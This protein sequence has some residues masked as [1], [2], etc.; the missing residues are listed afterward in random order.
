MSREKNM[1]QEKELLQARKNHKL[2]K[3]IIIVNNNQKK[4]NDQSILDQVKQSSIPKNICAIDCYLDYINNKQD[5]N[6]ITQKV[7]INT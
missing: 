1:M 4:N 2:N 3:K 5:I 6:K 7:S